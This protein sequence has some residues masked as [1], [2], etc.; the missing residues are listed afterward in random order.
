MTFGSDEVENNPRIA[1]VK[2]VRLS[3]F[4]GISMT[5]VT[6]MSYSHLEGSLAYLDYFIVRLKQLTRLRPARFAS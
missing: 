4:I 5:F 2:C 6:Y 1:Q 3:D